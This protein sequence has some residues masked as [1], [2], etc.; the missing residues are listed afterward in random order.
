MNSQRASLIYALGLSYASMVSLAIAVNLAPVLLTTLS[1]ALGG[2]EGL[3]NEQL[4]RIGAT[5]FVGLVAGIVLAGPL[6]D[7]FGAK[8]FAVAANLLV[9]AGLAILGLA[10]G[11]PAVLAA[12]FVMG[13]GAGILD[14]VLSPIVSALQSDRRTSAMNWLHSFYSIG[15][16]ATILAGSLM[17]RLGVGW[18]AIALGLIA[19]PVMV[20]AGFLGVKVPPLVAEGRTRTPLLRLGRRA[21]F[22]AAVA[23]IFLAGATELG[24]AQWLPAY[25]EVGLGFSKWTGGMALL[26]FSVAMAAGRIGVGV[27]GHR[28]A[29]VPLMIGCCAAAVGLFLTGC[30]APWPAV[31]LGA[32]MGVG[33]A[34]SCLWPCTLAAAADRFP[35][36]GASMF[37]LL[38]AVGNFGGIFMPW[39]IGVTA[40]GWTMRWGIATGTFAPLAMALVLVWVWRQPRAPLEPA[41]EAAGDTQ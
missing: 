29:A 5:T 2:E 39:V 8:R 6:A 14:L 27:V 18:R 7:R 1:F 41:V 9:A 36:G 30:F 11:Y 16:V 3:T 32:C 4:G 21:Y 17:L 40:D 37:G 28:V 10:P 23:A 34:V 25:A 12:V 19:V 26:A 15:A 24:L 13:L 31:A 20:G 22:I 33:L 35:H 38:S